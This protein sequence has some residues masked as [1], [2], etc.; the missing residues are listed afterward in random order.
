MSNRNNKNISL[1]FKLTAIPLLIFAIAISIM[2]FS[3]YQIS[4]KS[5]EV[6]LRENGRLLTEEMVGEI[7]SSFLVEETIE[8]QM[9]E[10]I[11]TASHIIGRLNNPTNNQL[12]QIANYAKIDEVN[13]INKNKIITYSNVEAN[14]G[15]T[16]KD[17]SLTAVLINNNQEHVM[18]AVRQSDVDGKYY[19]YG[20]V[21]IN[22][23]TYVQIGISAQKLVD[24][25]KNLN[26][27]SIINKITKKDSVR[28][29][30]FIDKN[31]IATAHSEEDR[32]GLDLSNDKGSIEAIKNGV[33]YE[34]INYMYKDTLPSFDILTPIKYN[35]EIVG[36]MNIGLNIDSFIHTKRTLLTTSIIMGFLSLLIGG[37]LIF[38]S[39]SKFIKPIKELVEIAKKAS[40][41][42]LKNTVQIN[43]TDEI[44]NLG[45]SFN[46]MILSLKDMINNIKNVSVTIKED[47][48]N[49]S[50]TAK[51]V[52][53]VSEQV[54][55]SIQ[56][57]AEGATNQVS[58]T[59]DASTHVNTVVN[60]IYNMEKEIKSMSDDAKNTSDVIVSSKNQIDQMNNQMQ[61][62][63]KKVYSSSETINELN[64]TSSEIVNIVNIINNIA[65][66]TNLLALNASIESARAGEAGRGF[67]VVAEEIRKLA[68]DT[69][70]SADNIRTLVDSTQEGTK[71]ALLT[72]EES[73]DET[74]K[75]SLVLSEVLKSL[76]TMFNRFNNSITQMN[77][78]SLEVKNIKE[79]AD[80]V[81]SNVDEIEQISENAAA[82]AE[83][84]AA[85]TQEQSASVQ[86][87]TST[88]AN[89]ENIIEDLN[90]LVNK[91]EV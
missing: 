50:S 34:D 14:V 54:A 33:P 30:L 47:A 11:K 40:L 42:N 8:N 63:E 21:K 80:L 48:N 17:T 41:G 49:I 6:Q 60:D 87:I 55:L 46:N 27:Q 58:S 5:L 36:A 7:Q 57:I 86:N 18:E 70:A 69:I 31:L 3:F 1:K 51:E 73:N 66:Q 28:Y 79:K 44:G 10:R 75:G 35:G 23:N 64:S 81:M 4:S 82:N 85:S 56:D 90:T 12:E 39:I 91:F 83:E 38:L 16:Y 77:A 43:S 15:Y 45:S 25:K 68:E 22:D 88:I 32:I 84:V 61:L 13:L 89:L 72:I 24:I 37:I 2:S 59:M 71:K 19:K 62:I 20:S 29:A 26:T 52:S 53:N 67:A 78:L 65:A 9:E 74:K 76:D